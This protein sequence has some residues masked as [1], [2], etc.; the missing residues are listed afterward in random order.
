MSKGVALEHRGPL[1][2]VHEK[3][4]PLTLPRQAHVFEA[5]CSR[6]G[7]LWRYTVGDMNAYAVTSDLTENKARALNLFLAYRKRGVGPCCMKP[8]DR[9]FIASNASYVI[10]DWIAP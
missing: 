8:D 4:A 6:C 5:R 10:Y 9:L 1:I 2:I 7:K 3:P